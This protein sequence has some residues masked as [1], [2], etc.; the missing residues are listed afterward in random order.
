MSTPSAHGIAEHERQR[1]VRSRVIDDFARQ[2]S[3]CS[4]LKQVLDAGHFALTAEITPPVACTFADLVSKAVPL[5][6]LADA[7]NVTDGANARAHMDSTVA[8]SALLRY[9]IEPILQIGCR[10]RNRIALQSQ[11]LGAAALGVTN[12]LVLRGDDPKAGDQPDAK[13]VF[14]LDTVDLARTAVSLRDQGQLPHGRKVAGAA[15]FFIG[16]ADSPIDPATG[17]EPNSLMRKVDAGAQFAQT[18][19]CMDSEILRRYIA[20]LAEFGLDRRLHLLVGVAPL[21]SAKS[22]RWIKAHLLGSIIP[23]WIIDRLEGASDP[24]VEG[25]AI[26]V[27][28]LREYAEIPGVHGA[29]IMGPHN[30]AAIPRVLEAARSSIV[31]TRTPVGGIAQAFDGPTDR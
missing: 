25:Q 6:G 5:R 22:A 21:P 18:Q 13:P 20:R 9:G 27:D 4:R 2:A 16:V 30:P 23:G 24:Q 15:P 3:A 28:L 26:C 12:I 19:F 14:D 8:A 17:W 10:D 7:V 1:N 31:C 29:H 11:L